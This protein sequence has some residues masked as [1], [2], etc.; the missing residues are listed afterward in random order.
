ME[1]DYSWTENK[2]TLKLEEKYEG[3]YLTIDKVSGTIFINSIGYG[4]NLGLDNF[5]IN[6]NFVCLYDINNILIANPV[7]F[8]KIKINNVLYTDLVLFSNALFS[9]I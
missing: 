8:E 6:N 2:L 9:L 3:D 5:K 4:M 7:S 1:A